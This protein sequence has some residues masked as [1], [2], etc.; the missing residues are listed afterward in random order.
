MGTIAVLVIAACSSQVPTTTTTAVANGSGSP[1]DSTGQIA[2]MPPTPGSP[3]P[4]DTAGR[5]P[6]PPVPGPQ[7]NHP[8]SAVT[9]PLIDPPIGSPIPDSVP[10][11]PIVPAPSRTI[12]GTVLGVTS[13]AG[14]DSGTAVPLAGATVEVVSSL[15]DGATSYGS[16]TTDAEGHFGFPGMPGT[17]L[18]V[19]ATPPAGSPDH[20]NYTVAPLT[21]AT[22]SSVTIILYP[23]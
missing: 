11:Q 20:A 7:P 6:P 18:F 13:W 4:S 17:Q 5:V 21:A 1:G 14:A 3:V 8:D 23:Y 2:P 12:S 22:T 19:R 9:G 15:A 10:P 16:A